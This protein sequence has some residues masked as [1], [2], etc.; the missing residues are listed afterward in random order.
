MSTNYYAYFNVCEHCGHSDDIWHL[1]KK[2]GGWRFLFHGERGN[3][4]IGKHQFPMGVTMRGHVHQVLIAA[5]FIMDE[6][7]NKLSTQ[8]FWDAV[9]SVKDN[10]AHT[11]PTHHW[12]KDDCDFAEGEWS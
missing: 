4:Y 2:S 6:Y 9:N 1:G 8:D 7:G 11:A 5:D 10:A 3:L 12:I